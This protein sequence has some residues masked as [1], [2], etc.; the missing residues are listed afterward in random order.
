[1]NISLFPV[2]RVAVGPFPMGLTPHTGD[3]GITPNTTGLPGLGTTSQI[4]G[5]LL[6]YGLIAC[7]AGIVI[8]AIVWAVSH[9]SGNGRYSDSGKTGVLVAC[10]GALLI[11]GANLLV[12][13]FS[14]AGGALH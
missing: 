12:T 10:G 8:S 5:A 3:P 11:G 2:T 7:V 1:M 6:S 9:H 4:V 14:A 13:F